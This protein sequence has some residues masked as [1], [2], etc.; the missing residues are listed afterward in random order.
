M[1]EAWA[2]PLCRNDWLLKVLRVARP[3]IF[4][5]ELFVLLSADYGQTRS[6]AK[7]HPAEAVTLHIYCVAQRFSS[8]FFSYVFFSNKE[9][10]GVAALWLK[11]NSLMGSGA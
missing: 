1:D 7:A 10:I 5:V 8:N 9:E 3:V 6:K 4:Q 11:G 2:S